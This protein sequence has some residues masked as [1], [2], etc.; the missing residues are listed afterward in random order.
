MLF[1][2]TSPKARAL[3]R[4]T[5]W[6]V[7]G[8]IVLLSITWGVYP[9]VYDHFH[10]TPPWPGELDTWFPS[11]AQSSFLVAV[12]L[13]VLG[14]FQLRLQRWFRRETSRFLFWVFLV[15]SLG[16]ALDYWTFALAIRFWT[17]TMKMQ[18]GQAR[19]AYEISNKL[20]PYFLRS[21]V[22][23]AVLNMPT[24]QA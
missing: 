11:N 4:A 17:L 18:S 10:P 19:Q 3:E 5:L 13:A 15:L 6:T 2:E 1:V 9:R 23:I 14:L 8:L 24:S 12:L 16:L 20:A 22:A 21:T 7:V